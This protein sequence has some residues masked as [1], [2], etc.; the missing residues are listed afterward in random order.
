ML[1]LQISKLNPSLDRRTSRYAPGTIQR[2]LSSFFDAFKYYIRKNSHFSALLLLCRAD[3][4]VFRHRGGDAADFSEDFLFGDS[5]GGGVVYAEFCQ[6]GFALAACVDFSLADA[7]HKGE[8]KNVDAVSQKGLERKGRW[9][10]NA[11]PIDP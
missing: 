7:G 4:L 10:L 8:E 1:K 11:T 9:S 2:R 3:E 5:G 6:F